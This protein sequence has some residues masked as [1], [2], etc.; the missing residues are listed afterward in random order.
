MFDTRYIQQN[1]QT[2]D[3]SNTILYIPCLTMDNYK[4]GFVLVVHGKAR[5]SPV[6][7]ATSAVY[8]YADYSRKCYNWKDKAI[9]PRGPHFTAMSTLSV[10]L[11]QYDLIP[12]GVGFS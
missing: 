8:V 5:F 9:H 6:I 1:G 12:V 10:H 7:H 2:I 3:N 4:P 11:I